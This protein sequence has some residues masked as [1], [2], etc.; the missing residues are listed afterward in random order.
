ME[1][2]QDQLIVSYSGVESRLASDEP[3]CSTEEFSK[4][5][6]EGTAWFPLAAFSKI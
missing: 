6:V 1:A 5:G 3:E 4:Q 2:K